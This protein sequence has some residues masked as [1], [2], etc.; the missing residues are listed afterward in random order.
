MHN[1]SRLYLLRPVY[2]QVWT[3]EPDH[4]LL[5][6][7][8]TLQ[9][10]PFTQIFASK[11]MWP[12]R[13]QIRKE[14]SLWAR[15]NWTRVSRSITHFSLQVICANIWPLDFILS[16]DQRAAI[17]ILAKSIGETWKKLFLQAFDDFGSL[18]I[19][20]YP[21]TV[22]NLLEFMWLLRLLADL[23]LTWAI[24][25]LSLYRAKRNAVTEK[26]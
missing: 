18:R 1:N 8:W 26:N 3:V 19:K 4:Y 15:S 17:K 11:K 10:E 7:K 9:S 16:H 14:N 24:K 20:A 2:L 12:Y 25:T 21:K 23:K 22:F 5:S 13:T 6:R